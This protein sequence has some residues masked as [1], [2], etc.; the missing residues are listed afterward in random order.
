MMN[1]RNLYESDDLEEILTS[2]TKKIDKRFDLT[3]YTSDWR[4]GEIFAFSYDDEYDDTTFEISFSIDQMSIESVCIK[5]EDLYSYVG[6]EE[7]LKYAFDVFYK[8]CLKI[9]YL[10]NSNFK[11]YYHSKLDDDN[12]TISRYL[13]QIHS[14]GIVRVD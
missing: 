5:V 12:G 13:Q 14:K 8:K 2:L 10:F 7:E 4:T 6:R 11:K 1:F 3:F 9:L